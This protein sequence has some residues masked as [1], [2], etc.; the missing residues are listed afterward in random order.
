MQDRCLSDAT[1]QEM[2]AAARAVELHDFITLSLT[3][4]SIPHPGDRSL[5]LWFG[6][7]LVLRSETSDLRPQSRRVSATVA[8]A[9]C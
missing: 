4:S 1:S 7:L 3:D 6:R 2:E 9:W 5:R 8:I